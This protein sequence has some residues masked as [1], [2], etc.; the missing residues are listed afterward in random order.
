MGWADQVR[1]MKVRA[2]ADTPLDARTARAF[3]AEGIGLCRTEHMFF[4]EE[5]IR[6]VREMILADDVGRPREGARQAAPRA[7]GRLR[8]DLP[9]DAGLPVTIR[10]LDPP[11]HEFLPH[12]EEA[13]RRA[14]RDARTSRSRTS[15]SASR[16][17]TS[18]TRCSAIAAAGSPSRSP[19]STRCRCARS[20][21]PPPTSPPRASSVLPEIMIPLAMTREELVACAASSIASPPRSS[22]TAR[23]SLS[24]SAR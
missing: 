17:C 18:S 15:R 20:S 14:R 22:R 10:L 9:R 8:G 7:E 4:D 6:A 1:T 19:R 24:R 2:N 13:D 12:G 5:R 11:L 3:G 21:R 16:T 23:A